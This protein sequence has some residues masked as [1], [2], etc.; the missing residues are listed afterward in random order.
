MVQ[1][2]QIYLIV[3][4][5]MINLI[6]FRFLFA[7]YFDIYHDWTTYS[8]IVRW[9]GFDDMYYSYNVIITNVAASE[10][11]IDENGQRLYW[12]NNG[13]SRRYISPVSF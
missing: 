3:D 9:E 11:A 8:T 7:T 10:L 4:I 2:C 12:I 5:I 6:S 13:T 1:G